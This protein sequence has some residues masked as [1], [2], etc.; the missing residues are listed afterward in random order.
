M[1]GVKCRLIR[2]IEKNISN[3]KILHNTKRL[4]TLSIVYIS[5]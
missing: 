3:D 5:H 1:D 2:N 4:A